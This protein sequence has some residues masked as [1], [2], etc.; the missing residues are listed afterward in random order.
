[1]EALYQGLVE[2][3]FHMLISR[4]PFFEVG[5]IEMERPQCAPAGLWPMVW[6]SR[7][8]QQLFLLTMNFILALIFFLYILLTLL[9]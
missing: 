9:P 3:L 7:K 4:L 5:R 6:P 1:M 8:Q 2:E